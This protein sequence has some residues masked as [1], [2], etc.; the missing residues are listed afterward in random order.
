MAFGI[1]KSRTTVIFVTREYMEKVNAGRSTNDYC[2]M[3][4]H[5]AMDRHKPVRVIACVI[6]E[7]MA[8]KDRWDGEFRFRWCGIPLFVPMHS[9]VEPTD[10]EIAELAQRIKDTIAQYQL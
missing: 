3:E 8:D 7:D 4:F 9:E 2:C 10:A 1:D 5:Y 6:D